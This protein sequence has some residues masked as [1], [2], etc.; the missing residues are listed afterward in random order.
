M[1]F[2]LAS[3]AFVASPAAAQ[4]FDRDNIADAS[5]P[6]DDNDALD[7]VIDPFALDKD[8]GLATGIP[9]SYQWQNPASDG[10][11]GLFGLGFT[12]L[13]TDGKTDYLSRFGANEVTTTGGAVT[14]NPVGPGDAFERFNSQRHGFQFGVR[15]R[16]GDAP[17]TVHTRVVAPFAGTTP[18]DFQSMGLFVGTGDQDNYV[19]VT[20]AH[21]GRPGIQVL[22]EQGGA[23]AALGIA[24]T[25]LPGPDFVDL[26]LRVDPANAA[27]QP[28]FSTT[29]GGTTT[30]RT[31]I[32][33]PLPVPQSWFTA[34]DR[35]LAV[36]ILSTA[37]PNGPGF[38][39]T[40]DLLEVTAGGGAAGNPSVKRILWLPKPSDA[41]TEPRTRTSRMQVRFRRFAL[42]GRTQ[43]LP[44]RRP[45]ARR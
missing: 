44:D 20:T 4:D 10:V 26:Y 22:N 18:V 36:G 24:P 19:K 12:G 16:P 32:G 42:V 14:V 8:N 37:Y 6:N 41:R 30:R 39:A 5:D 34:A 11:G 35:G 9:V 7:D 27:V 33:G 40:W 38:P 13:M 43:R 25:P 45:L 2:A 31:D 1:L 15:A 3:W 29:T 28:S 17:F 21:I 23:V